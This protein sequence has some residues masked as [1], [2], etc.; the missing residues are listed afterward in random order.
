MGWF[1]TLKNTFSHL[2]ALRSTARD[3]ARRMCTTTCLHAHVR[4][5]DCQFE[6]HSGLTSRRDVRRWNSQIKQLLLVNVPR[7]PPPSHVLGRLKGELAVRRGQT[8]YLDRNQNLKRRLTRGRLMDAAMAPLITQTDGGFWAAWVTVALVCEAPSRFTPPYV[9]NWHSLQILTGAFFFFWKHK[10]NMCV[11][12]HWA[13]Q[14]TDTS[15]DHL[16][17]YLHLMVTVIHLCTYIPVYI[18]LEQ[19]TETN[20]LKKFR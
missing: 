5:A 20:G 1:P 6:C 17:V 2:W 7:A 4:A 18:R 10:S 16:C 12:W 13:H 3:R 19:R 11:S 8:C 15:C 14:V 9:R